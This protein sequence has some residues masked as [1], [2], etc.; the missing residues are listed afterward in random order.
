MKLFISF[1]FGMIW[2]L[3]V[4]MLFIAYTTIQTNKKIEKLS[5]HINSTCNI[6]TTR[7]IDEI[8]TIL[9]TSTSCEPN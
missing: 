4:I 7:K 3:L 8:Y 1:T 6:D 5:M 9:D 2:A